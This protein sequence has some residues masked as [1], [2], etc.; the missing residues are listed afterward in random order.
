MW[1]R[2]SPLLHIWH[3]TRHTDNEAL[4]AAKDAA[5]KRCRAVFGHFETLSFGE[6]YKLMGYAAV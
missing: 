6:F 2:I 1:S 5:R 4:I 3:L